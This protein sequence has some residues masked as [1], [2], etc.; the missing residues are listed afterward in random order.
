MGSVCLIVTIL[1]V[2]VTRTLFEV[3]PQLDFK[4]AIELR[5]AKEYFRVV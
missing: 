1:I 4:Q 5:S 3:P 2:A